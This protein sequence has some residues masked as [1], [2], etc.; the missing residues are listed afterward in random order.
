LNTFVSR[1]KE[2]RLMSLKMCSFAFAS[3]CLLFAGTARA[4]IIVSEVD[5]SGSGNATY[6]ADW[7]ELTNTGASAVNIA[8]WTMDDNSNSFALSVPLAGVTSINAGQSVVFIETT[9]QANAVANFKAAWFGASVPAGF[10]IGTYSGSQVGLSQ[11]TDD[12]H[13]FNSSGTPQAGVTF[14]LA[15]A[16]VSFDNAAGLSGSISQPSVVGVNGAFNSVTGGEIGSPG[17]I[18]NVPEPASLVLGGM[19]L[20]GLLVGGFARRK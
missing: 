10:T 14:G 15:T 19:G 5:P 1:F 18:G 17:T 11:T 7:F 20:F 16:G 2:N 6:T 12:V 8:G 13:I 3:I 4:A 9:S